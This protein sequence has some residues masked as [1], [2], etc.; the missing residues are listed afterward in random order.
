VN[1]MA[2]KRQAAEALGRDLQPGEHITAGSLVTSGLSRRDS[3]A[4]AA[5]GFASCLRLGRVVG[6]RWPL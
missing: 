6:C 2:R 3:A 4:L 1:R 5:L